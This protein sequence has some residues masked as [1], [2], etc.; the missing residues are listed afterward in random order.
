MAK[1]LQPPPKFLPSEWH[2]A[3][4][5]QY[6]RADA[7]RSRSERLVAESQRLVDEIEKTT[8]KSQ[9]DVNKKLGRSALALTWCTTQW[10][11]S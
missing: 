11:M 5:N 7:Q 9:S 8:R 2:I 4:K 6:H 10:S 3:N 1:L